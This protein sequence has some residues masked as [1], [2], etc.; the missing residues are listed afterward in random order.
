MNNI[1]FLE[2]GS[3]L[4]GKKEY[5]IKNV[6]GH[7][8]CGILYYATSVVLDGN[9][10]QIH[11]Y[12]I[13][14]YFDKD[15]CRRVAGGFVEVND[16]SEEYKEI[17]EEFRSEAN[18]LKNLHHD[19]IVQVNE[20]FEQNGTFYY[21]MEYLK[22][23]TLRASVVEPLSEKDA[24]NYIKDV[25]FALDYLHSQHINHLD[26]KPDNIMLVDDGTDKKRCVL[27][28]FGLSKHFD[29]NGKSKGRQG[30]DGASDGYS[31][32]EQYE[33]IDVFTPEADV[34]SL[35]ATLFFLLTAKDPC[36]GKDMTG[37]YVY[38]NLPD[39]IDES[40]AQ[41]LINALNPDCSKRTDSI[42]TFYSDLTGKPLHV[43]GGTKTKKVKKKKTDEEG[44]NSITDL[45]SN[46]RVII[47]LVSVL[48]IVIMVLVFPDSCQKKE[49]PTPDIE[50]PS[51]DPQ[52]EVNDN[53]TQ[54]VDEH[55]SPGTPQESPAE[56]IETPSKPNSNNNQTSNSASSPTSNNTS[57]SV[58]SSDKDKIKNK[59]L[60]LGYATWK[61][62]VKN[63]KPDGVGI[64]TFRK[65]HKLDSET[66]AE[67]GD[68]FDGSFTDG[69]LDV[70]KLIRQNGETITI[71]GE[72]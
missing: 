33:G 3:I 51:V 45:L 21:V 35:A 9:I 55:T 1:Q 49:I 40:T 61:G 11:E 52:S 19:N 34:Y 5:L 69:Q 6:L 16:N 17:R 8:G 58:D 46:K 53:T 60:D 72:N 65:A 42:E 20:V 4:Q 12:A 57:S 23:I 27:I 18:C 38:K 54:P 47:V 63:G 64:M 29:K 59:S 7:G 36:S 24:I 70:G 31:P 22:G 25:A 48:A 43:K 13:K 10:K 44:H 2:I 71:I 37:K 66:L 28:D 50:M 56:T 62:G 41:A 67:P 39:E 26:V 32:K 15:C 30:Y 68:K 14:E